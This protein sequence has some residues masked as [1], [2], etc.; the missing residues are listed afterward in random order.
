M[1]HEA[2]LLNTSTHQKER[3]GQLLVFSGKGHDAGGRSSARA[4]S[5]PSRS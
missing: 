3:I 4:T 5:V 1:R 2:Q